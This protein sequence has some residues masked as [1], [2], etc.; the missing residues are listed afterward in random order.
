MDMDKVF[1]E[2]VNI[3]NTD[4]TIIFSGEDADYILEDLVNDDKF[5]IIN[6]EKD[7]LVKNNI[8]NIINYI[9]KNVINAY[10]RESGFGSNSHEYESWATDEEMVDYFAVMCR[11]IEATTKEVFKMLMDIDKN[12]LEYITKLNLKPTLKFI[13]PEDFLKRFKDKDKQIK[14]EKEINILGDT[15]LV[16][17]VNKYNVNHN[18]KNSAKGI[19]INIPD[20]NIVRVSVSKFNSYHTKHVLTHELIHAFIKSCGLGICSFTTKNWITNYEMIDWFSMMIP[21]IIY[22]ADCLYDEYINSQDKDKETTTEE[23]KEESNI[24]EVI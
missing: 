12:D 15:Y 21:K 20:I 17:F 7:S 14:F 2:K 24:N 6:I 8:N 22:T 1:T 16:Q 3:M 13:K 19:C 23:E 10:L 9:R 11:K 18:E 5:I 4:Y